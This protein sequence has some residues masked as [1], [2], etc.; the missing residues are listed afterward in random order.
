MAIENFRGNVTPIADD[1]LGDVLAELVCDRAAPDRVRRETARA[2]VVV[3]VLRGFAVIRIAVVGAL[4]DHTGL[5]ESV[6]LRPNLTGTQPAPIARDE[7]LTPVLV[8]DIVTV[9][10]DVLVEDIAVVVVERHRALGRLLVLER[11]ARIGAVAKP[12]AL[13]V[14]LVVLEVDRAKTPEANPC[15]PEDR[16]DDVLAARA[17]VPLEVA[18]D[19]VGAIGV[20]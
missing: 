11:R 5:C 20:E 15:V 19:L 8:H 14:G 2:V 18:D 10:S 3:P 7:R 6:H 4:F 9:E 12:E 1:L 13:L 16:H 17:L